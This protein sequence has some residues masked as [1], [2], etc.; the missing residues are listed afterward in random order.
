MF[1]PGR[2]RERFTK[3]LNFY[4]LLNRFKGGNVVMCVVS[5]QHVHTSSSLVANLIPRLFLEMSLGR[6]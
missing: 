6:G 4:E 3:L 1:S 5:I 2:R